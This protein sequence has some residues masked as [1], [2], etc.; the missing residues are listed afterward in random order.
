MQWDEP[1]ACSASRWR[2]A[3][4]GGKLASVERSLVA[5]PDGPVCV[6][7]SRSIDRAYLRELQFVQRG[8]AVFLKVQTGS[9][10][11]KNGNAAIAWG[12]NS[13]CEVNGQCD[14]WD[15]DKVESGTA[16]VDVMWRAT[17]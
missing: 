8:D 6:A 4:K 7:G 12:P 1:T 5:E 11:Q 16:I 2:L 13:V 10:V 14:R 3:F 15:N 17:P 9:G